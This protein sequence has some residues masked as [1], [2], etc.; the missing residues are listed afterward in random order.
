VTITYMEVSEMLKERVKKF[1][2]IKG[3]TLKEIAKHLGISEVAF[4]KSFHSKNFPYSKKINDI[5]EFLDISV[6]ELT[7]MS[8]IEPEVIYDQV[9][10]VI[11]SYYKTNQHLDDKTLLHIMK[12]ENLLLKQIIER[13]EKE[14]DF[15]RG[16]L[17]K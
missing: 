13:Q 5:A 8:E 15:L 2:K 6:E 4:G 11:E 7:N 17:M 9:N 12:S 16:Q 14:I 10:E 1:A 3:V